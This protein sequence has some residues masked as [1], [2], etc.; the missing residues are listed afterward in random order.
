MKPAGFGLL[1]R[2]ICFAVASLAPLA[3]APCPLGAQSLDAAYAPADQAPAI[4]TLT[5]G[6]RVVVVE[7]HA[8]PV[9]QTAVWYH[10]GASDERPGLTG[11]AHALAHMMYRGTPTLS[12]AGLDDIATRLGAQETALTAN[13]YT[14]Y[15]FVVP[16]DKLA[17][18]L[19]IE[20]DRMQ[21]LWLQD[22]A[23]R[24]EKE[25]VLAEHDGDLEQPLT[26]LYADVCKA[27]TSA[28]LCAISPLGERGDIVNAS[29]EDIRSYYQDWYAPN[30][31]TLV[32]TGDVRASDV[33]ALANSLFGSIPAS[34]LPVRPVRPAFY[35]DG[36]H[37][38]IEGDFP[39]QVID[40]AFRAPGT[41]DPGAAAMRIVDTIVNDER[42][43]FYKGLIRSGYA[44]AYSTQLDQNVHAGLYHV[45]I[46]TSP[47]HSSGQVRDAFSDAVENVGEAGYSPDLLRAAK[48]AL[49]QRALYARDSVT[50]L[51]DR[52]GYAV[53]VEGLTDPATDDARIAAASAEDL[54]AATQEYLGAPAAIGL[55]TPIG[56]KTGEMPEPPVSALIDDFSRRTSS[57]PIVEPR[58][59]TEALIVP[60]KL[61][62]RV[63]PTEFTLPNGLRVLVE[64]VH[65]NP[66]V[67]V[68]GTVE[69]SPAFDPPHQE[70][71]GAMVSTLLSYGG[72]KYDFD[73]QREVADDLGAT[74]DFG[75]EFSAH[76]RAQDLAKLIDVLA[77]GLE[78][79][80]FT[81]ADVQLVRKQTLDAIRARDQDPDY[82]AANDFDRMLLR[83]DDP[84]LREATAYS[85]GNIAVRDLHAYANRYLRPDLTTLTIVG[86]VDP[87]AVAAI[88]RTAFGRWRGVG[89]R[90]DPDPGPMPP[91]HAEQRYVVSDRHVVEAHLGEASVSRSNPHYY[92]VS[93]LSELL[94]ADGDNDTRL[95][96]DLR[97]R[98]D[99]VYSASS[100]LESDQYR[101]TLNFYLSSDIR[102]V[103]GAVSALR[104]E[105]ERLKVDPVGPFEMQRA[106]NKIVA[107][108]LVDEQSTDVIASRVQ[109]IGVDKLPLGYETML[110]SRYAAI[111]GLDLEH[112]AQA[113]LDENRLIEVY[114]GPHI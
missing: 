31:A 93:L 19:G 38:E 51:G 70:G 41:G 58:W 16:A 72:T 107:R 18:M 23:W 62:T 33:F 14:V 108:G 104:D 73:A 24:S 85:V 112:A 32:V 103:G 77:D 88:V 12:G 94:G 27:A 64:A 13:D 80:A 66:T 74:I 75:E 83:P 2:W 91:P 60:E 63:H 9:V 3:A 65:S 81:I 28:P 78:R 109:T 111:D 5:N 114:E 106:K 101:G 17:L 69:T 97:T 11:L 99:L 45:F 7:D 102:R 55:L 87:A 95:M 61:L 15:R 30:N 25:A 20:A 21:H 6:L 105:L 56:T 40:L 71:T 110:P 76:G 47:G 48:L 52:V 57:G 90:P 42:S 59:A 37:V 26:H 50:G 68:K 54:R 22:D 44:L 39:Y 43:D 36:Q 8:A 86:D 96:T 46:V 100:S 53:A 113:Y 4:E 35:N 10:F 1:R 98:G 92:E 82:R 79:P 49:A 89:P 29:S 34:G 84:A 67:F